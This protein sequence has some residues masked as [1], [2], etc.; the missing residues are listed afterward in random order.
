MGAR[1][2]ARAGGRARGRAGGWAS[3]RLLSQLDPQP[4]LENS[5]RLFGTMVFECAT[6]PIMPYVW[7][8]TKAVQAASTSMPGVALLPFH[9]KTVI[10]RP[11]PCV[12]FLGLAHSMVY[13]FPFG[14]PGGHTYSEF[15]MPLDIPK[16]RFT[17][18]ISLFTKQD[19]L[20][21]KQ[22]SLFTKQG[23]L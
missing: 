16:T 9:S 14:H 17:K 18:Q 21:T 4:C 12:T 2:R 7:L 3:V 19:S 11:Q 10:A 23:H 15:P 6:M 22:E 5:R 13:H 1:A 20:F 8:G